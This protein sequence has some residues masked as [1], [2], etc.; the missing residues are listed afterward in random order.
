MTKTEKG[1]TESIEYRVV[2]RGDKVFKVRKVSKDFKVFKGF[3][4]DKD[5][6]DDRDDRD[7]RD[8]VV[9]LNSLNRQNRALAHYTLHKKYARACVCQK[10]SLSL[11]PIRIL[12]K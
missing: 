2:R 7:D 1:L 5:D 8:N 10:K 3:K 9:S 12:H 6:K 11:Q 4:D